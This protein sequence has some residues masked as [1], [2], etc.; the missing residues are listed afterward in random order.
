MLEQMGEAAVLAAFQSAAAEVPAYVDFLRRRGVDPAAVTDLASFRARVPLTDKPTMFQGYPLHE[1]FRGGT[2][3]GI[4]SFVPSSG[5]SGAFAFSG[6][7]AE[8]FQLAAKGA[9]L[10]FE[11]VVG[12]SKRRTLLVNTYPMGLQVPTSM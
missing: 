7:T 4:K 9:D 3:E 8:G 10:A 6:D 2:L 11:Y 12:F 5:T 1:L